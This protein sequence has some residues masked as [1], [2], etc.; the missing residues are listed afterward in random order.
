MDKQKI[1]DELMQHHNEITAL[2]TMLKQRLNSL[3]ESE[4]INEKII[5]AEYKLRTN[6]IAPYH[7]KRFDWF[8]AGVLLGRNRF[9]TDKEIAKR[10][11]MEYI[12][13][14]DFHAGENLTLEEFAEDWLEGRD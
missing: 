12:D 4:P 3:P 10:L 11:V 13:D 9:E 7:G 8:K 6:K 2:L 14:D 1:L 5:K